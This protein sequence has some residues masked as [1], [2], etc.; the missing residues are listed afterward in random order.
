MYILSRPVANVGLVVR[1]AG[2]DI[3]LSCRAAKVRLTMCNITDYSECVYGDTN[4][5]HCGP[6]ATR[7]LMADYRAVTHASLTTCYLVMLAC[8]FMVDH[9]DVLSG[10]PSLPIKTLLNINNVVT[11]RPFV[12]QFDFHRRCSGQVELDTLSCVTS[13]VIGRRHGNE[14]LVPRL[15][16]HL[17]IIIVLVHL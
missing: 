15:I 12:D 4:N 17:V 14:H 10:T 1:C 8:D 2:V 9:V 11:L 3:A 7:R 6:L 5:K 13:S 16:G